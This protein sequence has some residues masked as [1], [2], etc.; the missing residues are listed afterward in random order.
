[1]QCSSAGYAAACSSARLPP[2]STGNGTCTCA[3]TSFRLLHFALLDDLVFEIIGG[4]KA[5]GGAVSSSVGGIGV[6]STHSSSS[7]SFEADEIV[8]D[9]KSTAVVLLLLC[10]MVA[11]GPAALGVTVPTGSSSVPPPLP[12]WPL[13]SEVA[14]K[15][16]RS[17]ARTAPSHASEKS[18]EKCSSS[19]SPRVSPS[20]SPSPSATPDVSY[21]P[22]LS[23]LASPLARLRPHQ[24]TLSLYRQEY[25]SHLP[26]D[27][28]SIRGYRQRPTTTAAHRRSKRSFYSS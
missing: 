13:S 23:G 1:M 21:T 2:R 14:R 28:T 17:P 15:E 16:R 20:R 6:G 25:R 8:C 27:S 4:G 22:S 5:V 9:D 11:V 12:L 26:R 10:G 18:S 19:S 3:R 7:R 24:S